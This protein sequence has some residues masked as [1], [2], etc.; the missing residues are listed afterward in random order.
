MVKWWVN[1]RFENR[2]CRRRQGTNSGNCLRDVVPAQN[3]GHGGEAN[4]VDGMKC[5]FCLVL[6][7]RK[8]NVIE[9]GRRESLQLYITPTMGSK[10]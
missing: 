8:K 1:R 6:L 5:L 7:A 10:L 4:E 2:P 9:F 3:L